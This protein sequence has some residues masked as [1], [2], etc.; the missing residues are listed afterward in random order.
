ML[1]RLTVEV[2]SFDYHHAVSTA[3]ASALEHRR[4]SWK[5]ISIEYTYDHEASVWR[6]TI[7]ASRWYTPTPDLAKVA[8]T[9]R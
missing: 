7:K 9:M 1:E 5:D 6:A 8:D 4:D 2:T 3:R